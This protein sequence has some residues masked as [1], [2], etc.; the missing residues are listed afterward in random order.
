MVVVLGSVCLVT[1]AALGFV[2]KVTADPIE[3]AKQAKLNGALQ[4]V[5][6]AFDNNPV[7]SVKAIGVGER[8]LNVYTAQQGGQTVGY[9][10]E[11]V[12]TN[13]F[14]GNVKLLVGFDPEG[15]I[16]NIE[17]LEQGETPGLGANMSKADN[18]LVTSLK[19]KVASSVNFKV[20]KDGGDVDALTAATISSRA[21]TE[22]VAAAFDAFKQV[23]E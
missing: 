20:R 1:S 10:V 4:K 8:A 16:L 15:K 6:P 13:G 5:V 14:N 21:Y 2:Y 19:G 17:V 3:Q 18:N 22:A 7:E 11:S 12:S 9:A 23:N